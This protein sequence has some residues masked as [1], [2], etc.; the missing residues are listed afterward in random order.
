M[1]SSVV[2]LLIA[3]ILTVQP[4]LQDPVHTSE[5]TASVILRAKI[6][7]FAAYFQDVES[8]AEIVSSCS[9]LQAFWLEAEFNSA[10]NT[11]IVIA[12][13]QRVRLDR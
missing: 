9:Y 13:I 11:I 7:P 3:R 4:V 5:S 10:I 1:A 12:K 6:N 2:E 8:W